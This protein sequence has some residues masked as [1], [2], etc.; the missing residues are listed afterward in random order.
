MLPV[1]CFT[2]GNVIGNKWRQ[3]TEYLRAG[4]TPAVSLDELGLTHKDH[5]CCRRMLLS[6][7]DLSWKTITYNTSTINEQ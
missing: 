5:S 2:C 6:H 7:I 1:R 4:K 3:Y